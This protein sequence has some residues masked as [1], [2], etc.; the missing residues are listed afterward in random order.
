MFIFE[1]KRSKLILNCFVISTGVLL[2]QKEL[3]PLSSTRVTQMF[4]AC[5]AGI[6]SR[7]W[8]PW[9]SQDHTLGRVRKIWAWWL[10]LSS[11]SLHGTHY[12][13]VVGNALHTPVV[14]SPWKGQWGWGGGGSDLRHR[15][16]FN[17]GQQSADPPPPPPNDR[18]QGQLFWTISQLDICKVNMWRNWEY[19]YGE[20]HLESSCHNIYLF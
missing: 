3:G 17:T 10:I 18:L 12:Q 2:R 7:G 15:I 13:F 5:S 16:E 8:Q 1:A 9:R 6:F 4:T 11:I 19:F 20:V 14:W